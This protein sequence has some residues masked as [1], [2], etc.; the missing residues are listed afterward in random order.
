MKIEEID[1]KMN[2]P[3]KIF[4]KIRIINKEKGK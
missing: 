1:K 2:I 4:S 3:I